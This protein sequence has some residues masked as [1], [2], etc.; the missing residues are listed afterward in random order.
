[1]RLL[2]MAIIINFV[3]NYIVHLSTFFFNAMEKFVHF[4]YNYEKLN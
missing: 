3:E 4:S 1:M 2:I